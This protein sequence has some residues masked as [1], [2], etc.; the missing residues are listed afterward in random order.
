MYDS[1]LI[2]TDGSPAMA[3]AVQHG[4]YHAEQNDA[5]LHVLYVIDVRSFVM[6][7]DEVGSR[8]NS[9][10][11]AEGEDAVNA[12]KAAAEDRGLDVVAA[13]VN[14]L[15]HEEILEYVDAED[16]DLVVM[17][18]H[19][20]TGDEHRAFGSVAEEV[21][22]NAHIPVLTVRMTEAEVAEIVDEE[23][24]PE[25]QLRYIR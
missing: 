25:A 13:V 1:I 23:S 16:I 24:T 5:T 17:G 11:D 7:P 3:R 12:I 4:L 2:P 21:V 10:L 8:V 20:R 15:P 18:T 22:R 14:G 19:G 9:V 6:L